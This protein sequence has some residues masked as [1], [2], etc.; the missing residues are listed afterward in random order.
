MRFFCHQDIIGLLRSLNFSIAKVW[1]CLG[2]YW[3]TRGCNLAAHSSMH[4]SFIPR[5]WLTSAGIFLIYWNYRQETLHSLLPI[6]C[7]PGL[8]TSRYLQ[9][10][11]ILSML[12]LISSF[13][14]HSLGSIHLK[15]LSFWVVS[16]HP[17]TARVV[18]SRLSFLLHL[19]RVHKCLTRYRL[20]MFLKPQVCVENGN[21][22]REHQSGHQSSYWLWKSVLNFSELKRTGV[23]HS[24]PHKTFPTPHNPHPNPRN[25]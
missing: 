14:H 8:D 3:S 4:A 2:L 17:F 7:K 12:V 25:I 13:H 19:S 10:A 15:L 5:R 20:Q 24:P 6:I 16:T 1:Y 18:D 23:T 21:R 22:T 9:L 11:T